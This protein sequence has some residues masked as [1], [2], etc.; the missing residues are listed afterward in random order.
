MKVFVYFM[1]KSVKISQEKDV[2]HNLKV[3]FFYNYPKR[4]LNQ[5]TEG[6]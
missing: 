5:M 1:K 3:K 6:T 4:T 2:Y